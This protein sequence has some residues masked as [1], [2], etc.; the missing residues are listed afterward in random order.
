MRQWPPLASEIESVL[1]PAADATHQ[2]NPAVPR[3]CRLVIRLAAAGVVAILFIAPLIGLYS[4]TWSRWWFG[5]QQG[6]IIPV[7]DGQTG[8]TAP[9]LGPQ[10]LVSDAQRYQLALGAGWSPD[11]AMIAASISIAEN[12]GG[13][14]A[15]RCLNCV[16]GVAEDSRGLWQINVLAHL[17]MVTWD[18]YDP[19]TNARAA[20]VIYLGAGWCAW[21]TYEASCGP[22]HNS[23]Y[24]Q[25][26]GRALAARKA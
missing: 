4:Q 8:V 16:P 12:G 3:G 25:Y 1:L 20:R 26:L 5:Q 23:A 14:P 24:R 15:Q 13:N 10:P 22:G 7:L 6:F 18:L 17:A 2:G 21:S 11:E 19:A 9:V